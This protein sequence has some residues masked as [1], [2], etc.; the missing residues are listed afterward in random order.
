MHNIKY[1]PILGLK[2]MYL[3]KNKLKNVFSKNFLNSSKR[4]KEKKK[5][6]KDFEI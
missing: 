5:W 3:L 2:L 4:R 1:F 6:I